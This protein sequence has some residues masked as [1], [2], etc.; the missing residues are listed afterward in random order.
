MMKKRP[1]KTM[2]GIGMMM[3]G[4][5]PFSFTDHQLDDLI[6]RQRVLLV[7]FVLG[8]TFLLLS[9]FVGFSLSSD[10]LMIPATIFLGYR[11]HKVREEIAELKQYIHGEGVPALT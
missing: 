10:L 3:N 8:L 7:G 9:A 1:L 2:T 11:G 4:D 6:N 5:S